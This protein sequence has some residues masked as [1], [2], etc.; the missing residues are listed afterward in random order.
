MN[1]GTPDAQQTV[2][3]KKKL[4]III[5]DALI[6]KEIIWEW[7]TPTANTYE[8]ASTHLQISMTITGWQLLVEEG[9]QYETNIL[10]YHQEGHDKM[11]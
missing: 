2:I 10:I 9:K 4:I 3:E 6:K 5:S 11:Q 7:N 8:G 1:Y